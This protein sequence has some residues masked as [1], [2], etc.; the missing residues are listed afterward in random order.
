[1]KTIIGSYRK[2]TIEED[3]R[4]NC[5]TWYRYGWVDS[6]DDGGGF[7]WCGNGATFEDCCDQIDEEYD[8]FENS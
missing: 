5:Y 4:F 1:M 6:I 3:T 7:T 8:K 2:C